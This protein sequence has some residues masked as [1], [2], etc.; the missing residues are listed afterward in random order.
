MISLYINAN[1]MPTYSRNQSC[2]ILDY[3]ESW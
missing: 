2:A 3:R 1:L